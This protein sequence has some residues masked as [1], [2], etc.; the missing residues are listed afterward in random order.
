MLARM[1]KL[2]VQGRQPRRTRSA[3]GP[4]AGKTVVV[5]GTLERFERKE[6]EQLIKQL[7]GKPAGSVS[8]KPDLVVYGDKAGSK[9]EKARKLGVAILTEAEFVNLIGE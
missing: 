6:A 3:T 7:G 4:L 8:K 5:T 2:G 1:E 9:L